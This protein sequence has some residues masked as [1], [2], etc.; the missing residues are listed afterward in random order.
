MTEDLCGVCGGDGSTCE[1][2]SGFYQA[3]VSAL[4]ALPNQVQNTEI[5]R[6]YK[7]I[8]SFEGGGSLSIHNFGSRENLIA[9]ESESGERALNWDLIL[10]QPGD[11]T[12]GEAMV[13]YSRTDLGHWQEETL[14]IRRVFMLKMCF[15][16][17]PFSELYSNNHWLFKRIH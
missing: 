8:V 6:G 11:Y 13:N 2:S 16:K 7:K 4:Q 1:L 14:F 9:L 3:S 10:K 5:Y 15:I 12:L 17:T